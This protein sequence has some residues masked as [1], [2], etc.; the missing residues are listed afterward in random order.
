MSD[1]LRN[2]WDALDRGGFG[3]HGEPHSFRSRCPLHGGDN[4]DALHVFIGGDGRAVPHC[5]A[6][7]A[8][9]KDIAAAVGLDPRDSFP[10][11]H[12]RARRRD[13]PQP[14][15]AELAGSV[16]AIVNVLAALGELGGDW[17]GELRV[18]CPHCGAPGAI[19]Q[20]SGRSTTYRCPGDNDAEQ[21]GFGAC[22][23]NQALQALAGRVQDHHDRK[24]A[25]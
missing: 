3:P 11:G 19:L 4:A 16:R 13:L 14:R 22:T 6:C 12:H 23:L 25:A 8:H 20:A 21:L 24:E 18:D 2:W 7:Q 9:P 1:P 10:A 15:R 5:F 17:Y